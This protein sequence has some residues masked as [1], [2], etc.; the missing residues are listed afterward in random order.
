MVQKQV[1]RHK[2]SCLVVS[3]YFLFLFIPIALS[4]S[5]IPPFPTEFYGVA[6]IDGEYLSAGTTI[7]AK[8]N[9]V[10]RASIQTQENGVFGGS[11]AVDKRLSIFGTN[12]DVQEIIHFFVDEKEFEQTAIYQSQKQHIVL[13]IGVLPNLP[14]EDSDD[15]QEETSSGDSGTTTDIDSCVEDWNCTEWSECDEQTS[16]QTRICEDNNNCGSI[17]D[18]PGEEK[19]CVYLITL[20]EYEQK[21][22]ENKKLKEEELYK[23]GLENDSVI[24][25]TNDIEENQDNKSNVDKKINFFL[26]D[27]IMGASIVL[28]LGVV[29]YFFIIKF[30]RGN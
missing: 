4:A 12:E 20:E 25:N 17:S 14:E 30:K 24:I 2:L 29:S 27:W 13:S 26:F 7:I 28:L 19:T 8:I 23:Q 3:A 6:S 21:V 18:K 11:G 9:N 5:Q 10:E 1:C 15:S 22:I 16:V